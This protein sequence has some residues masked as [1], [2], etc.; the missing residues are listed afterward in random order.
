MGWNNCTQTEAQ[1]CYDAAKSRFNNAAEEY[2]SA[3]KKLGACE[4][5]YKRT[6]AQADSMRS[7]K[8][9][10]EKR[11]EQIGDVIRDLDVEGRVNTDIYESNRFAGIVEANFAES[12]IC[13]GVNCPSITQALKTPF[14]SENRFSLNA[15]NELRKEKARL[16]QAIR[17]VNAKLNALEQEMEALNKQMN[18]LVQVQADMKKVIGASIY[19]MAH[20]KKY[21]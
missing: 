12:I 4:D 6:S 7:D 14:V 11:V 2:T 20:F 13:S 21:M 17:D 8:L 16:E 15:L 3:G 10:F 5:A 9:N 18:A 19:D 1:D